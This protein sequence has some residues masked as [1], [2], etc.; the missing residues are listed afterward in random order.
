MDGWRVW[1]GHGQVADGG[2]FV[3]EKAKIGELE[4]NCL[5]SLDNPVADQISTRV[6]KGVSYTSLLGAKALIAAGQAE[7]SDFYACVGYSGWAP[8]QLQM[9][10]DRLRASVS[11]YFDD[12]MRDLVQ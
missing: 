9:E 12:Y 10:V 6:I 11:L 7:K 2:L 8:G 5:H 4:V 3:G 1:C